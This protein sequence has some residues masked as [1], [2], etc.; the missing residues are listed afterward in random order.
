MTWEGQA[1]GQGEG[2]GRGPRWAKGLL[3]Q[4]ISEESLISN[5]KDELDR[6]EDDPRKIR[7]DPNNDRSQRRKVLRLPRRSEDRMAIRLD[8]RYK[9]IIL[10][11]SLDLVSRRAIPECARERERMSM[12]RQRGPV[13]CKSQLGGEREEGVDDIGRRE[14]SLVTSAM[15]GSAISDRCTVT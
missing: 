7:R 3:I 5:I 12:D 6:S 2:R 4:R 15:S 14:A 10:K 1:E 8:P 9:S 13:T 11:L